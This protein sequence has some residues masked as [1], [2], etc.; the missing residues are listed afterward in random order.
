MRARSR[1][2]WLTSLATGVLTSCMLT[3]CVERRFV[4][5]SD[6]PGAVV[7]DEKGEPLGATP[8]DR[9]FTYYG[10][11]RFMLV[12]D[13][14]QTQVVEEHFRTP[15]YE[16]FPV[17]FISEVLVPIRFRDVRRLHYTMQPAQVVP[18]EAV[19]QSGTQLQAQGRLLG[20]PLTHE[21]KIP[22]PPSGLPT[23]PPAN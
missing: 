4:I 11:Y 23:M 12:R 17:D 2:V 9:Q 10:K 8:T 14:F 22:T 6:P 19:L 15:W 5:T 1:L 16:I 18:P 20:I 21:V 7:F 3:G 13:G